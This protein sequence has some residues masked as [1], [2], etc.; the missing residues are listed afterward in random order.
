MWPWEGLYCWIVDYCW[1]RWSAA[2]V[3]IWAYAVTGANWYLCTQYSQSAAA[4]DCSV[5][6]WVSCHASAGVSSTVQ[7]PSL[8]TGL[9][10]CLPSRTPSSL[11]H[12]Y[13]FLHLF[14]SPASACWQMTACADYWLPD[15][16]SP[17]AQDKLLGVYMCDCM[18]TWAGWLCWSADCL[19]V[20]KCENVARCA[21]LAVFL[22]CLNFEGKQ[23]ARCAECCGCSDFCVCWVLPSFDNKG[24]V[25]PRRVHYVNLEHREPLM[26]KHITSARGCLNTS[27]SGFSHTSKKQ[28]HSV[29]PFFAHLFIHLFCTLWWKFR[30]R[31]LKV[32]SPGHVK[33]PHRR[34]SSNACHNYTK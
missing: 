11:L 5:E 13:C 34:K 14:L 32:R 17:W 12:G 21:R 18:Q 33:W 3:V 26:D 6:S 28:W 2:L 1:I 19:I 22:L 29:L 24:A 8:H 20:C 7:C 27:P 25:L 4:L 9:L 31:P 16:L 15:T 30:P 23:A 10:F